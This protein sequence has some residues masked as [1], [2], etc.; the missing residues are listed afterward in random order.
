MQIT[1]IDMIKIKARLWEDLVYKSCDSANKNA[2]ITALLSAQIEAY[3][4]IESLRNVN[5]TMQPTD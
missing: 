5:D 3:E 2:D 1:D 4:I